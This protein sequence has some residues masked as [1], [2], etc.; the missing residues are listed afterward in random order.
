MSLEAKRVFVR[1][2]RLPEKLTQGYCFGGGVPITFIN[3]DW[4]ETM[5]EI[6]QQG[7]IDFVKTKRYY[8]PTKEYLVLGDTPGFIFKIEKADDCTILRHLRSS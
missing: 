3:V 1:I 8:D 6:G 4:F 2:Y 5:V 7:L